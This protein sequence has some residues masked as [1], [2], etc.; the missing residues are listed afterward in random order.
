MTDE[1]LMAQAQHWLDTPEVQ[2]NPN[3]RVVGFIA[4]IC[5]YWRQNKKI[6]S[7]QRD[8]VNALLTKH[9]YS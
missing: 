8:Y 5:L 7:K 4:N 6:T 3:Y 9:T 2:K 1:L